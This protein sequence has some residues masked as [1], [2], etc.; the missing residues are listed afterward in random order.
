MAYSAHFGSPPD[1]IAASGYDAMRLLALAIETAGSLESGC[2]SE[3]IRCSQWLQRGDN[4][5]ALRCEPTSRQKP[6]NP[7]N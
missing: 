1:G 5:F 6:H 3:R 4:H 7:E 2:G